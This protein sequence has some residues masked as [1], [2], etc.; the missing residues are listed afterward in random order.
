MKVFF[1]AVY[2]PPSDLPRIARDAEELGYDGIWVSETRHDPFTGLALAARATS[3]I[4]LRTGLAVAFARNPMTM[5]TLAN[6]IQLISNGRFQLGLGSQIKAHIVRRFS[7]P[8]SRPAARMRE[9]V[10]AL[11]T[12]WASYGTDENLR[13][14]GEFYRHTLKDSFFDPGPNPFG[15]PLIT[16]GGVGPVMTEMAGEVA[17]GFLV[18]SVSSQRFLT[19]VTLPALRRGRHRGGRPWQGFEVNAA[20]IVATGR[21]EEEYQAAVLMAKKQI[22]FYTSTPTY[23]S[24]LGLHGFAGLRSELYRLALQGRVAEM[25]HAIDSEVLRTFAIVGEPADVAR[26]IRDR[27]GAIA[28]TVACYN[29]D[30]I[31]PAYW[32]PVVAELR[33]GRPVAAR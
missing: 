19:E 3:H 1:S 27:F 8:W 24:M 29:P 11:R 9:Y 5:A 10:T 30:V 14:H 7:M 28:D 12:I 17:D 32:A 13:F 4:S 2:A 20:P 21:T 31:D 23:S 18:H 26:Q 16:L 22:A 6:D 33:R 25:P 15:S